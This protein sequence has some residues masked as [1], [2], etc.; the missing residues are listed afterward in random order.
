[1]DP[2]AILCLLLAAAIVLIVA[3]AFLPTHGVLGGVGVLLTI[4]AIVVGFTISSTTGAVV[5]AG[6]AVAAPVLTILVLKAWQRSPIGKRIT[7]HA[8]TRPLEHEQIHVGDHG[9]TISA[10]RPMGEA[11]FGPV[12]VQVQAA[13]GTIPAGKKIRVV[14]Y[15]DGIATVETV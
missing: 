15:H 8:T 1:M 4:V 9:T 3:E 11:E 14:A 6:S 13:A 12:T 7:L 2:I 5:F 10:L